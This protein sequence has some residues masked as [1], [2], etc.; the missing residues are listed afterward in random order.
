MSSQA[1]STPQLHLIGEISRATGFEGNRLFC[2]YTVKSGNNWIL[3][4][5]KESGETYEEIKNESEDVSQWDHPF[6]I[7]FKAK[8]L[9]GWPKFFV[10]VWSADSEGRYSIAGYG[11]GVVPFCAGQTTLEIKCWRPKPQGWYKWLAAQVLGI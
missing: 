2:K 5:G 11:V 1:S 3:V 10:E 4:S 6:D 8:A 7:H 9:R